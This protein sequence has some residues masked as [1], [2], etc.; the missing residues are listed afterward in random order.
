MP[1]PEFQRDSTSG[2]RGARSGPRR[3]LR[4]AGNAG[5]RYGSVRSPRI[6]GT[7]HSFRL[8]RTPPAPVLEG[9]APGSYYL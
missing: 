3:G 1:L 6:E 9:L 8:A 5:E 2:S 4:D 7:A